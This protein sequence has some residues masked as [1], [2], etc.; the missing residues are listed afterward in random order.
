MSGNITTIFSFPSTTYIQ[1]DI[2]KFICRLKLKPCSLFPPF[3]IW[4]CRPYKSL[5]CW[6]AEKKKS[7]FDCKFDF[8]H[9]ILTKS[10][11]GVFLWICLFILK[12][13]LK[14]QTF[15]FF[16]IFG[17]TWVNGQYYCMNLLNIQ[18]SL[19]FPFMADPIKKGLYSHS[20]SLFWF[21]N[22]TIIERHWKHRKQDLFILSCKYNW[23]AWWKIN[24]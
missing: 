2:V 18:C 20:I 19:D 12:S 24:G 15:N 4:L 14:W 21:C 5:K 8:L 6:S 17:T 9:S 22:S 16:K 7:H 13:H 10:V 11:F 3:N 23:Q 1:P